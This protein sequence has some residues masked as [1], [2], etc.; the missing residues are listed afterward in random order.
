MV[1]DTQSLCPLTKTLMTQCMQF[2]EKNFGGMLVTY[3]LD[4][5]GKKWNKNTF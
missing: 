2:A 1:R 4:S 5:V 3:V